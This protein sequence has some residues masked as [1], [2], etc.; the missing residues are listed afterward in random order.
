[1]TGV[2]PFG[3]TVVTPTLNLT[4]LCNMPVVKS[5][6]TPCS[7]LVVVDALDPLLPATDLFNVANCF[8]IMHSPQC[9]LTYTIDD[10]QLGKYQFNPTPNTFL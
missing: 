9:A 5:P 10:T 6:T 3:T 8:T 4:V 2:D 1:M 7:G